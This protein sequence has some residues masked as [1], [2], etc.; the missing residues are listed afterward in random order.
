[1]KINHNQIV[2]GLFFFNILILI[3]AYY[4]E[5]ILKVPA[6]SMC[7]YQRIPYFLST[8]IIVVFFLKKIDFKKLIIILF[9]FTLINTGL[10]FYHIGIEQGFFNE[11]N[12]CKDEINASNTKDL[13]SQLKSKGVVSCKEVGFTIFGLSLATINFIVNT[14]LIMFY[15]I[16]LKNEK[17]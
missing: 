2:F 15:W 11:L 12:T 7:I 8:V 4:I 17:N 9:L 1:M 10:S 16:I 5:Y 14:I 6:C 13:L 3:S